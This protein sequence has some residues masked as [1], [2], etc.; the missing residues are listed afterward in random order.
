MSRTLRGEIWG[1][2]FAAT[3]SERTYLGIFYTD[4]K[5]NKRSGSSFSVSCTIYFDV[6]TCTIGKSRKKKSG[7]GQAKQSIKSR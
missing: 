1:L 6:N 2:S 4:V 5:E 3:H 7:I